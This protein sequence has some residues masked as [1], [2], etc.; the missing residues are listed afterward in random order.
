MY[1]A[2]GTPELIVLFLFVSLLFV[3]GQIFSK[4]GYS[5][6]LGVTM[7]IPLVNILVL[8]WFAFADWP[9]ARK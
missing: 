2:I 3:F 7:I 4:A 8:T 9:A 1:E 5:R 6:W